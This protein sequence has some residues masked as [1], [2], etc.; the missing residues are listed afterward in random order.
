M[1][2]DCVVLGAVEVVAGPIVLADVAAPTGV[3]VV[4]ADPMHLAVVVVVA[5]VGPTEVEM[6]VDSNV[7]ADCSPA[8]RQH[9]LHA[10]QVAD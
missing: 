1:E 9:W 10:S 5:V 8:G 7:L 6:A 2:V 3:D 4:A